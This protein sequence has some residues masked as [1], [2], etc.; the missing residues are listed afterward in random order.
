MPIEHEAGVTLSASER[1]I[2][3]NRSNGS[4][5]SRSSLLTKGMIGTSRSR[6]ASKSWRVC[7]SMPLGAFGVRGQGAVGVSLKSWWAEIQVARRVEQVEGEPLVLE[8]HRR[9]GDRDAA[10]VLD[11]HP[12]R[13]HPPPLAARLDLA[14][15]L[16]RLAKQQ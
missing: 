1:S 2:S 10:L 5:P 12:I 13:A 6:H 16:D 11:R 9:R 3:S 7:S 15:Q 4:R 8:A 14:R